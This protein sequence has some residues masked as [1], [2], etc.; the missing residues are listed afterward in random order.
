M[1]RFQA[2]LDERLGHLLHFFSVL[3]VGIGHGQIIAYVDLGKGLDCN[4]EERSRQ[5]PVGPIH[6]DVIPLDSQGNIVRDSV[7][8]VVQHRPHRDWL[9]GASW[10]PIAVPDLHPAI[11]IGGGEGVRRKHPVRTNSALSTR[12]GCGAGKSSRRPDGLS[13]TVGVGECPAPPQERPHGRDHLAR[14]TGTDVS[15]GQLDPRQLKLRR[16]SFPRPE[17]RWPVAAVGQLLM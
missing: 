7:C 10:I 12:P 11:R 5:I 15:P 6:P 14:S 3:A 13:V 4:T 17:L 1:E 8:R 2:Q 9:L 16:R